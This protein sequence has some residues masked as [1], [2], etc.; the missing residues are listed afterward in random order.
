MFGL[1]LV[2][3]GRIERRFGRML[4]RLKDEREGSD[5]DIYSALDLAAAENALADAEAFLAEMRRYLREA[6]G[7]G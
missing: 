6:H 4:A 2:K 5:Y 3:T 1:H 7:I